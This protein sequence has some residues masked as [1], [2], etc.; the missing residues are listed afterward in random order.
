MASTPH[1]SLTLGA[2]ASSM[3]EHVPVPI[4]LRIVSPLVT[5]LDLGVI[6]VVGI[7]SGMAYDGVAFGLYGEFDKYLASSLAA[8]MLYL[9]FARNL[10]LYAASNLMRIRWQI[11]RGVIAWMAVFA[12]LASF[13]FL[14]K[15]GAMLSRGEMVLFFVTGLATM[16]AGRVA[17]A[18][19]CS[20][21]IASGAL[22]PSQIAVVGSAGE[23]AT[24]ALLAVLDRY[25]YAVARTVVVPVETGTGGGAAARTQQIHDLIRYVRDEAITEVWIALPWS[26]LALIDEVE[27]ALRVL[28]VPVKLVP[29]ASIGRVL[30]RPLLDIGATR[31]VELQRAPLSAVQRHVKNAMDR[32]LAALG[33]FLLAPFIAVI[34]VAIRLESAGPVMFLQ[35]RVGFNG[36]RFRIYKFRTMTTCDDGP[37]IVQAKRGDARVTTLGRLL[38]KL[39]LDELPQLLNV[40]RGEMSLVG[41]RPHALA[42]DDEYTRLI[43]T[44]AMRHRMKPGITGWAQVNG[45]RG[46][47]PELE[48]MRRRVESDLWYVEYWSLWLDIR[49]L[50]LT[51]AVPLRASDVY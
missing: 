30:A 37:V 32:L 49:I 14:F 40:V 29:D 16:A 41:P 35:T 33:L 50:F 17:V 15:I 6:L 21:V 10:G 3:R 4:S 34:A 31:A 22:R 48:S 9:V 11:G 18:K 19:A 28:P 44:Y 27:R 5:L 43:A 36:Q 20:Y 7:A 45:F 26:S 39:S 38:R 1:P 13:A 42:H 2:P 46:E 47:T 12:F 51:V 23:L 8:A 24:N 25:G